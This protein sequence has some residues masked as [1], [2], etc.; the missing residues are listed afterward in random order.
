MTLQQEGSSKLAPRNAPKAHPKK[1]LLQKH[2]PPATR[3][4]R[5]S[6]RVGNI[7]NNFKLGWHVDPH[8]QLK[9]TSGEKWS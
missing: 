7:A 4:S 8:S 3:K 9:I 2:L 1:K 5:Y 6:G